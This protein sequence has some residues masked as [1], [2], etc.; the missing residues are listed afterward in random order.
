[1]KRA[2]ITGATGAIGTAL[3]NRLIKD[4]T[5]VL[6]FC[7]PGSE[8]NKDIPSHPLVKMKD[9]PLDELCRIENDTGKTY[10]LFYHL[11]WEG[12]AKGARNDIFLQ[13]RNVRYTLDAVNAAKRFG[14][15]TFIG[16]GSQA[17]YGRCS[18]KLTPRTP[19]F[20]ESGYGIAKLSAGMMSAFLARQLGMRHIWVRILSVY[21][22][23][24]GKA[25]MIMSVLDKLQRGESPELTK[26]EQLW[27]YLYSCDAA[28]AL[29]LLGDK[30]CDGKVYVLGSG[31]AL[32]LRKY[33]ETMRDIAAPETK[34]KFGAVP[35]GEK[36]V[37]YLCADISDLTRDTGWLP[38][39][40]FGDGI[41]SILRANSS[42]KK[43][44]Q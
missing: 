43:Q 23:S 41:R 5:E 4:G 28:D 42:D 37:M 14:C 40:D 8:R 10:D 22:P 3:I 13:N 38:V 36:Q 32:P 21:G 6:V 1:M 24:D 2:I 29:A 12:T 20:P 35:Y 19:A 44:K 9:C 33:V 39:T 31:N 11:A 26:G 34:V 25:S 16:A 7:R 18:E 27:D 15:H 17:E 30:G